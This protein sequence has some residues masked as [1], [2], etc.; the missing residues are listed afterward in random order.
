MANQLQYG[1]GGDR[2]YGLYYEHSGKTPILSILLA[3]LGGALAGVVAAAV[4]AYAVEYIP[5]VKIRFILTIGFGALVGAVTALIARAGRVRSTA[6]LM[7]LV[8]VCTLVAFYFS[9]VFWVKAVFDRY[10]D[11]SLSHWDLISSPDEFWGV[12]QALNESGTWTLS[13]R[14]SSSSSSASRENVHGTML[15]IVWLIE[16][17][18]IFVMAFVVAVPMVKAQMFC[19]RCRRWCG[20][21]ASLRTTVAGDDHI[22]RSTLEAHDLSYVAS[23]PPGGPPSFWDLQVHT[24]PGCRELNALTIVE[25]AQTLNK[26]GQVAATKTRTIVDKLLVSPAEVE[27]LRTGGV[28]AQAYA[29]PPAQVGPPPP[30]IPLE[31]APANSPPPPLPGRTPPPP[32]SNPFDVRR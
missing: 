9:W 17:G 6:V 2:P 13:S 14:S 10:T 12:I 11:V 5:F 3:A 18:A 32:P 19:E 30:P 24:C 23:L 1:M 15:T 20:A 29:P 16:A 28:A 21:P 4:Y 31:P 25:T 26:K 27:T 8:G 22:A 7:A